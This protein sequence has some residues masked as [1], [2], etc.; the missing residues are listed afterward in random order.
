VHLVNI[1][2]NVLKIY[3][4][5]LSNFFFIL[6]FKRIIKWKVVLDER[7]TNL[8]NNFNKKMKI[9]HSNS[10][11]DLVNNR[12]SVYFHFYLKIEKIEKKR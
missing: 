1:L 4:R 3:F 7:K 6:I 9:V 5:I 12:C 2:E 8:A 10:E 11:N